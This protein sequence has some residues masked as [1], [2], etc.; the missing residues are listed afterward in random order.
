MAVRQGF[1]VACRTGALTGK[2][3]KRDTRAWS[4]TTCAK[5]DSCLAL[6]YHAS[7]CALLIR[8]LRRLER[9][10]CCFSACET[11]EDYKEGY[12]MVWANCTSPC[13]SI[14]GLYFEGTFDIISVTMATQKVHKNVH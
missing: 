12:L 4:A 9:G 14:V 8:L 1:I 6:V 7:R 10:F 11:M 13:N 3:T 5:R 2:R